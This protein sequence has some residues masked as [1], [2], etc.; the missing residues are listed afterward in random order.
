VIVGVV[1]FVVVVVVDSS[2][3]GRNG[4]VTLGMNEPSGIASGR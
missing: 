1:V 2:S 4:Y 3:G